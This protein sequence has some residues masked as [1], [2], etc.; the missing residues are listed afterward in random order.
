MPSFPDTDTPFRVKDRHR[1]VHI[2]SKAS[3]G[4]NK[5]QFAKDGVIRMDFFDIL[6]GLFAKAGK[7]DLNLFLFLPIK[8]F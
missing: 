2:K 4:K 7:D 5:V 3:S 8:F 6:C 1:G